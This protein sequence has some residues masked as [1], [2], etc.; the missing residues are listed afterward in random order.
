MAPP[1]TLF[2]FGE[3]GLVGPV[4]RGSFVR[5][6]VLIIADAKVAFVRLVVFAQRPFQIGRPTVAIFANW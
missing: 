6:R 5:R 4:G 2:A 3:A 1:D